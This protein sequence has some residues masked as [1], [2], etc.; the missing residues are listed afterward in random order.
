V[1][2]VSSLVLFPGAAAYPIGTWF[3]RFGVGV[4]LITLGG[5]L[6]GDAAATGKQKTPL[7][8]VANVVTIVGGVFALFL[9]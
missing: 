6:L 4:T 3:V 9:G 7:S 2:V 1:I 5:A 8:T